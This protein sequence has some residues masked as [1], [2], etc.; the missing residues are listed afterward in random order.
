MERD[1]GL[2]LFFSVNIVVRLLF[3][4]S[5]CEAIWRGRGG[6]ERGGV[7]VEGMLHFS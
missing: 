6:E 5:C 2:Y 4:C 7:E 1:Y 3:F